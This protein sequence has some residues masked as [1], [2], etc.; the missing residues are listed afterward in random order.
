MND[1]LSNEQIAAALRDSLGLVCRAADRL[2]CGPQVIYER[3]RESPEIAGLF[4]AFRARL[5]DAAESAIWSGILKRESWAVKLAFELWGQS[6]A[7]TDGAEVWHGPRLDDDIP[8]GLVRALV[9]E[10]LRN[11]DYTEIQRTHQLAADTG[12]VCLPGEPGHVENDPAPGGDRPGD[13][14][15]DP[16]TV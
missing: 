3:A 10:L 1:Q 8:A 6:R 15:H 2:G 9:Q 14:G 11:A 4:R 13:R 16:G 5:L 7:F 12:A